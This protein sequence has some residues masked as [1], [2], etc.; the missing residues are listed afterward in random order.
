MIDEVLL[1]RLIADGMVKLLI[2]GGE[3]IWEASPSSEHQMT[4]DEMRA[5]S[6]SRSI[7]PRRRPSGCAVA[8]R[9]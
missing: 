8:L 3:H 1:E 4:V 5:G 9:S 2:V 7:W 6:R